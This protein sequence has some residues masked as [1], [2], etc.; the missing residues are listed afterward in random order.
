M[1]DLNIFKILFPAISILIFVSIFFSI[2][3]VPEA[4]YLNK[5]VSLTDKFNSIN[6]NN[7]E[8]FG[9]TDGKDAFYFTS[10]EMEYSNFS[11]SEGYDLILENLVGQIEYSEED[12]LFAK[13]PKA[14]YWFK[15]K[16]I[17]SVS[18][19]FYNNDESVLAKSNNLEIDLKTGILE[20]KGPTLVSGSNFFIT[21]GYLKL[22]EPQVKTDGNKMILQFHNNVH[23]LLTTVGN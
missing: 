5:N 23:A 14:K 2:R 16:K 3:S 11:E 7:G 21:S 20:S 13:S 12:I 9:L 6:I 8:I 10:S 4:D 18:N 19:V 15:E 1:V 22:I 17:L